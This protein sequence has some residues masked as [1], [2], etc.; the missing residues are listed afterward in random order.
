MSPREGRTV[1]CHIDLACA[2]ERAWRAWS[3]PDH[4]SGWLAAEVR[5]RV[6]ED[7]RV[8]WEWWR[9]AASVTQ[10]VRAATHER[11]MLFDCTHIRLP[12]GTERHAPRGLSDEVGLR[13]EVR[14]DG[15]DQACRVSIANSGFAED[16]H[17][18]ARV[19]ATAGAWQLALERLR[20][21]TENQW[22]MKREGFSMIEPTAH[23]KEELVKRFRTE[24]GLSTWLTERGEVGD[25]GSVLD[26]R[27]RN[28]ATLRGDV[29]AANDC[30]ISLHLAERN[31]VLEFTAHEALPQDATAP[32][33]KGAPAGTFAR[34]SYMTWSTGDA[35]LT[36]FEMGMSRAL[37]LLG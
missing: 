25:A 31:A 14:I 26:L 37:K 19:R 36:A 24:H 32:Q 33:R 16:E 23:S 8:E 29:L 6:V 22:G 2:R 7:A 1:L 17:T 11:R 30:G 3:E 15:D 9:P 28:G 35:P 13:L 34:V 4:A 21:Y 18:E 20:V 27:L 5:G 10:T 12:E